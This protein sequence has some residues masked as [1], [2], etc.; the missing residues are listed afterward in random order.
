M[1]KQL[2]FIN[3]Y[4]NDVIE[5][6]KGTSIFAS[7][8]MAQACLE[9]GYGNAI[10]HNNMFGFK[11]SAKMQTNEFWDGTVAI[12]GTQEYYNNSNVPTNIKDGFRV[13]KT[14]VDSIK[15]HNRLLNISP[16]YVMVRI[17]QTPE[18][19]CE[20]LRLCGYA[21]APDYSRILKW[22]INKYDLKSLD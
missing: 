22:I 9:T 15:D 12:S 18:D 2:D 11:G 4:K 6:C 5:A 13:Y 1:S 7:V 21:T 8:T 19:Q 17:S 10:F 16:R 3:K 20:A 14:V